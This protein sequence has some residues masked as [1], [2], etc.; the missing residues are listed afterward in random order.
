LA[1][2][3]LDF[4]GT[5]VEP[6]ISTEDIDRQTREFIVSHGAYPSPLGFKVDMVLL[7]RLAIDIK[8]NQA[9]S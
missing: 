2:K 1:K 3:S 4:A 8:K 7:V 6:G 5:L 9:G